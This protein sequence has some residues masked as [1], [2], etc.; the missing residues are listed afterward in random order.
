MGS[1]NIGSIHPLFFENAKVFSKMRKVY[2]ERGVELST[3]LFSLIYNYDSGELVS[4][5]TD[6]LYDWAGII[7][8]LYGTRVSR[9]VL[10]SSVQW[11]KIC[12]D[13]STFSF[14]VCVLDGDSTGW[15]GTI[16]SCWFDN[17]F[18][19]YVVSVHTQFWN[20]Q[21][22]S[23]TLKNIDTLLS[24]YDKSVLVDNLVGV[25]KT[26]TKQQKQK[27]EDILKSI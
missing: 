11:E 17:E 2:N 27:A 22:L 9:D 16:N 21:N 8:K 18:P 6:V 5:D 14:G 23:D 15:D 19:G 3:P 26:G 1:I 24:V 12:R 25:Y 4:E 7:T 20:R 13:W 10:Y